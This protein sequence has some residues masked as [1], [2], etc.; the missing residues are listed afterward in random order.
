MEGA[1][2]AVCVPGGFH[3]GG[4]VLGMVDAGVLKVTLDLVQKDG[5][6]QVFE[7]SGK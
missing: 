3:D 2:V 1:V 4:H 6:P 5:A 7:R